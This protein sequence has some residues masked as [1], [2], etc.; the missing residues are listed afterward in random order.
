MLRFILIGLLLAPAAAAGPWRDPGDS[1]LRHDIQVLADAGARVL[2]VG[3]HADKLALSAA[4]GI[5]VRRADDFSPDA[6]RADLVVEATG[7]PDGFDCAVIRPSF[8]SVSR[9]RTMYAANNR[10]T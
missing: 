5:E 2:H 3:R 9:W 8:P 10:I 4:R 6:E 7:S 1:S